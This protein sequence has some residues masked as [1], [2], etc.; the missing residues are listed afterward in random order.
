MFEYM[1]VQDAARHGGEY[2]VASCSK[3]ISQENR[4]DETPFRLH[5]VLG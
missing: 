1:T 5:L 2:Q 3:A 4:I